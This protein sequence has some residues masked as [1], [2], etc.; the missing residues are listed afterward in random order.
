MQAEWDACSVHNITWASN[1][2]SNV[3]IGFS[4]NGGN[5]YT[6]VASSV[7]AIPGSYAW[8]IPNTTSATRK[9]IINH[10]L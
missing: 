6:T 4:M 8:T 10:G 9:L 7:P 1:G 5:T 3:K 2:I